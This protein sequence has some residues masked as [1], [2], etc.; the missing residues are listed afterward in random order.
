MFQHTIMELSEL[1]AF[2]GLG[3]GVFVGYLLGS[4]CDIRLFDRMMYLFILT[5][6]QSTVASGLHLDLC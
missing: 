5:M 6:K 3:F 1:V 4:R 2:P